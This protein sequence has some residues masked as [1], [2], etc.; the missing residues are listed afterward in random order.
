MKRWW[1]FVSERFPLGS[2]LPMLA[3]FTLANV[4][5]GL[6][7]YSPVGPPVFDRGIGTPGPEVISWARIFLALVL[8]L[9]FFLRLRIFDEIK[10][11]ATDLAVNPTR[12]LAR[13]LISVGEAKRMLA[14]LSVFEISMLLFLSP[15]VAASHLLAMVYS[16]VMYK[17]FFIG[18]ILRPHLTTYAV[19]HTFVSVLVGGSLV[20]VVTERPFWDFAPA[21]MG[22][23]LI[24][25]GFFN[26][27]EFARKTFAPAE[28]RENVESYSKVF[29]IPGAVALS[30]SQ[31]LLPL[32]LL[33][34]IVGVSLSKSDWLLLGTLLVLAM[35][36]GLGF[37]IRRHA[38][39]AKLFRGF[40]GVYLILGYLGL[41]WVLH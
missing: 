28:E 31:A 38:F 6:A 7:L 12:P 39:G 36:P 9:S 1:I 16:F 15:I 30:L 11:Y 4:F 19:L 2:H 23:L 26:L 33:S 27:F 14:L 3:S 18:D 10:D 13:G 24:N 32:L 34:N 40:V 8:S 21:L 35:G 17:E 29:G 41:A 25:W 20:S 5:M 22:L 37:A